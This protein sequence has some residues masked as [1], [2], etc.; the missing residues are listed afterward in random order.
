M[1]RPDAMWGRA[2]ASLASGS[3]SSHQVAL[4]LAAGV[5]AAFPPWFGLQIV[6][7]VVLARLLGASTVAALAGTFAGNPFTWPAIW[8]GSYGVGAVLLGEEVGYGAVVVAE[9]LERVAASLAGLSLEALL[10]AWRPVGPMLLTMTVGSLPL[11]ATFALAAYV[12]TRRAMGTAKARRG[13]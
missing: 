2:R 11:G 8:A 5:F 7:A 12:V 1:L 4:G 9:R 10:A 13:T 3:H 6:I